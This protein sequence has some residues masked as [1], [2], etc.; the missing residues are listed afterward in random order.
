MLIARDAE[1]DLVAGALQRSRIVTLTGPGGVGKTT[2]ARTV[3]DRLRDGG[4]M[5]AFADLTAVDE[6]RFSSAVA[7][8]LG[9]ASVDDLV[10]DMRLQNESLI[11]FDNCEHVLDA[12]AELLGDLLARCPGLRV[13]ATSRER[14]DVA[15]EEVVPL[16]PLSTDGPDSD[17]RALFEAIARRHGVSDLDDPTAVSRLVERLDGLPLAVELAAARTVAMTP[18]EILRHVDVKLDILSRARPRGPERHRSLQATIAWSYQLLSDR[19]RRLLNRLSVI[20]PPF[21]AEMALAVGGGNDHDAAGGDDA[22]DVDAL[23]RLVD[24][25]LLVR[26]IHGRRSWYRLLD[27]I[28]VYAAEQLGDDERAESQQRL[29]D[30]LDVRSQQLQVDLRN[31]RPE[32]LA[33]LGRTFRARV[34]AIDHLYDSGDVDRCLRFVSGLWWLEDSGHQGEMVEVIERITERCTLADATAEIHSVLAVM[35]R[36]IGRVEE[37]GATAA[38]VV[39][40]ADGVAAAFAHRTLGLIDRSAGRWADAEHHFETGSAAA[41]RAGREDVAL[42]VSM[43]KAFTRWRAGDLD[44][45]LRIT[46]ELRQRSTPFPN[47]DAWIAVFQTML[48]M[49]ADPAKARTIVAELAASDAAANDP[50][51]AG[52]CSVDLAM[53]ELLEKGDS[54]L[55]DAA[56][57]LADGIEQFIGI[58]NRTD[59]VHALRV[60]SA[61]VT[62]AGLIEEGKRIAALALHGHWQIVVGPGE[63]RLMEK[64]GAPTTVAE[65]HPRMS[66]MATVAT[67]RQIAGPEA[68]VATSDAAGSSPP[69]DEEADPPNELRPDGDG[70]VVS[71]GGRS[72]RVR[73]TKGMATLARLLARPDVEMAAVDLMESALVE[74]AADVIADRKARDAYRERV[75]ELQVEI[76]EAADD[77]DPVRAERAKVE[78]DHLVGELQAAYG[79]A[80]S[81]RATAS[82]AE[83]ARSAVRWRLRDAVKRIES[84]HPQMGAHLDRSISTGRFC[85]YRPA[86]STTWRTS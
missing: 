24:R 74:Q 71:Y 27:T 5:A 52:W 66:P 43:H 67:L 62:R 28:R 11:V 80:G 58:E 14:L 86:E 54:A 56:R 50:W 45:A 76:D 81:E 15:D 69:L 64:L 21:T 53:V 60:A 3:L 49:D 17:A 6:R 2:L 77:N 72:S 55:I 18:S 16:G 59:I 39:A 65:D 57:Y 78:L 63:N 83:R 38:N 47:V 34:W 12:A 68:G 48:N 37:A 19:E 26:E 51:V 13:L 41:R 29:I 70:W 44:G 75:R 23:A 10:A 7:G 4:S 36:T 46:D 33:E 35:Y 42:E 30:Y 8:E 79:L 40:V 22:E 32:P 20:P 84:V 31:G 1:L 61:C 25:S 9:F 85:V 82:T 73:D